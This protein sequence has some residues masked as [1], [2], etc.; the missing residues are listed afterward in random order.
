[1]SELAIPG[2]LKKALTARPSAQA[3]FDVL[4]PDQKAKVVGWIIEAKGEMRARRAGQAAA[5]LT[6]GR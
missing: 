3:A 4:P 2:E 1:V 5:R 6:G